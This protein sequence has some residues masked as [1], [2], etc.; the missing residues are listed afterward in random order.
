VG[1]LTVVDIKM[2]LNRWARDRL[3]GTRL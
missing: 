1:D 2:D 3:I